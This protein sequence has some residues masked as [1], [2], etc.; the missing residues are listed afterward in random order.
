MRN[1]ENTNQKYT[2]LWDGQ[3]IPVTREVYQLM[4]REEDEEYNEW[5]RRKRHNVKILSYDLSVEDGY[6]KPCSNLNPEEM[7]IT[8]DSFYC[9][10]RE[11]TSSEQQLIIARFYYCLTEEELAECLSIRQQ[12]VNKKINQI[13]EKL[14]E[15]I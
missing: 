14:R 5:R 3:E 6:D 11:L 2:L 8:N 9:L 7:Y 10:I 1:D 15:S 13:L 4:F 12:N